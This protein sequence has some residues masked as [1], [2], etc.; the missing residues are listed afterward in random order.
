[1][2]INKHTTGLGNLLGKK[3]FAGSPWRCR[4]TPPTYEGRLTV[5]L[6][7]KGFLIIDETSFEEV[8]RCCRLKLKDYLSR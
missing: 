2:Q 8:G 3:D 5:Q 7:R 6:S 4:P 1:M